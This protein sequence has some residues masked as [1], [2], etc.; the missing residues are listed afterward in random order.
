MTHI[1]HLLLALFRLLPPFSS[2]SL[3]T[4]PFIPFIGPTPSFPNQQK[5]KC[6]SYNAGTTRRVPLSTAYRL[7]AH[8]LSNSNEKSPIFSSKPVLVHYFEKEFALVDN[9]TLLQLFLLC[10]SACFLSSIAFFHGL[11]VLVHANTIFHATC[12]IL[13]IAISSFA[14]AGGQFPRRRVNTGLYMQDVSFRCTPIYPISSMYGISMP[15][16]YDTDLYHAM[17]SVA[18]M[19]KG[20]TPEQNH[21]KFD[22]GNDVTREQLDEVRLDNAWCSEDR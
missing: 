17:G 10:L 11:A 2:S 18:H 15:P 8:F 3:L 9:S 6:G 19:I 14:K 13:R 20:K 22:I 1:V 7:P 21:A 4:V 16:R 12:T 5:D